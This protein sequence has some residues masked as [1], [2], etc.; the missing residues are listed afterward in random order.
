MYRLVAIACFSL[1]VVASTATAQVITPGQRIRVTAPERQLEGV[2][3]ELLWLDQ[4]SLGWR[5]TANV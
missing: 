4:D 3:G 1:P 5:V 2:R